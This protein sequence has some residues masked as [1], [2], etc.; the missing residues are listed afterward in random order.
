[1]AGGARGIGVGFPRPLPGAY[2]SLAHVG[3]HFYKTTD[4]AG[5]PALRRGYFPY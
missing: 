1:M 2:R 4:Q 5:A 3:R